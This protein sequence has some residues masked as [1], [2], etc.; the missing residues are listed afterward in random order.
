METEIEMSSPQTPGPQNGVSVD[1]EEMRRMNKGSDARIRANFYRQD[2]DPS[3]PSSG[4]GGRHGRRE[5][6]L[7]SGFEAITASAAANSN[8]GRGGNTSRRSK[9]LNPS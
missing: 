7:G 6:S 9:S 1:L 4:R 5:A 3:A 8:S 2:R